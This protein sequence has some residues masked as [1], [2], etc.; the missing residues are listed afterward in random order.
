MKAKSFVLTQ[1]QN[2]LTLFGL[3]IQLLL[4]T[5]VASLFCFLFCVYAKI[6][7]LSFIVFLAVFISGLL[8]SYKLVKKDCHVITVFQT[9]MAFWKGKKNKIL[10]TGK[11]GSE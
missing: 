1:L 3:P 8:V 7:G 9:T 4:L 6:I 10:I 2:P 11:R 5:A